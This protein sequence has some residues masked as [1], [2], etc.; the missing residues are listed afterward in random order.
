MDV[1]SGG[2][3]CQR[4]RL[5]VRG[6]WG[7]VG[8]VV[9]FWQLGAAAEPGR[10]NR[11]GEATNL[12]HSSTL[13]PPLVCTTNRGAGGGGSEGHMT[14][15]V[16]GGGGTLV[17]NSYMVFVWPASSRARTPSNWILWSSP[18][19]AIFDDWTT[20]LLQDAEYTQTASRRR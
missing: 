14:V 9:G 13:H 10:R 20:A 7:G 5:Q 19:E 4:R 18:C 12:R 3:T 17:I 15:C 8:G 1:R 11:R 16:E 2:G 6:V